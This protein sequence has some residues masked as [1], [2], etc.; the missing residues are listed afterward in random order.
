MFGF[1]AILFTK[2]WMREANSNV[3]MLQCYGIFLTSLNLTCTKEKDTPQ[4]CDDPAHQRT[5]Y[6]TLHIPSAGG[7]GIL[8]SL[9]LMLKHKT[10][11]YFPLPQK[12]SIA[13]FSEQPSSKNH[14]VQGLAHQCVSQINYWSLYDT[15]PHR[16]LFENIL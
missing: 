15:N 10:V 7:A 5:L 12:W 16:K 8:A 9:P 1:R 3:K 13:V 11:V 14:I 6:E 4:P 2:V